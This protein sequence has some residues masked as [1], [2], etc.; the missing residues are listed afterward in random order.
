MAMRELVTGGAACTVP[1]SSS[2]SNPL[3]A[4]ANAL[5]ASSSKTQERLNEIPASTSTASEGGQ[6]Y[7]EIDEHLRAFPGSEF[8]QQLLDPNAQGSEFLR[9]FRSTDQNELAEAW[10]E[11]QLQ[12]PP[13]S[14]QVDLYGGIASPQTQPT[15]DV[16][17]QR[18][19]SSLCTLLLIVAVVEFPFVQLHF[20]Y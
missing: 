20:H 5:I 17:P 19:L 16:P 18:V 1:G 13:V 14:P 8:D 7:S 12:R 3:G 2:Y 10:N 6:L 15:L 4:L 9:G 11:V